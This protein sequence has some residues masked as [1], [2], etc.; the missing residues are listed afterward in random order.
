M[1]ITEGCR[2]IDGNLKI[3]PIR[4]KNDSQFQQ[5]AINSIEIKR[6]ENIIF[7][8]FLST[9]CNNH[10]VIPV[11]KDFP[12]TQKKSSNGGARKIGKPG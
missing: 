4:H 10:F 2:K 3:W 11:G 1:T 6:K 5:N 12:A 7:E 9:L 8:V